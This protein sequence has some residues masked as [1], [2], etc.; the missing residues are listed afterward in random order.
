MA[1]AVGPSIQALPTIRFSF[2][3]LSRLAPSS[4]SQSAGRHDDAE[5]RRFQPVLDI[6]IITSG[7]YLDTPLTPERSILE[8]RDVL[9]SP[10]VHWS[11]P[12][13][14][15]PCLTLLEQLLQVARH[16]DSCTINPSRACDNNIPIRLMNQVRALAIY[17]RYFLLCIGQ[18][19]RARTHLPLPLPLAMFLI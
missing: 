12:I 11:R 16:G 17:I 3:L 6:I 14:C 5:T 15:A 10:C 7:Y 4:L 8:T 2:Y 1:P 18:L 9:H 19:H 13:P